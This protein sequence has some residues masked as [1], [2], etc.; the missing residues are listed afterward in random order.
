M[1]NGVP[2]EA[3]NDPDLGLAGAANEP[4]RAR[5]GPRPVYRVVDSGHD[6]P[7]GHAALV[8]WLRVLPRRAA[9]SVD[10]AA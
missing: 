10:T 4:M 6:T 5:S 3:A 2:L 1:D 9:A 8:A 7:G